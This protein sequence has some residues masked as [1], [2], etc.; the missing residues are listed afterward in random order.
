MTPK[1]EPKRLR[2]IFREEFIRKRMRGCSEKSKYKYEHVCDELFEYLGRPATVKD[3]D[4]DLIGD[5]LYWL[6]D[7]KKQSPH[8]ANTARKM[9]NSLWNFC[10]KQGHVKTWP[11]IPL[12]RC[13]KRA[14]IAWTKEQLATLFK[15]CEQ[16]KGESFYVPAPLWWHAIHCLIW[17]TGERIGAVLQLR[18]DDVDLDGCWLT[19]RAETRKWK[20]EDKSFR[21]HPDTVKALRAI[22]T[23]QPKIFATRFKDVSTLYNHYKKLLKAA[24]L[25]LTR[26]HKFHCLRK[27]AASYFEAAGGNATELLGHS[28]R[29]VTKC[30]LDP[31]VVTQIHASDV[32]FR[33]IEN[34]ATAGRSDSQKS[35]TPEA[36][37]SEVSEVLSQTLE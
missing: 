23:D 10:A 11:S 6:I 33:P 27:S 14:P 2:D 26:K 1:L 30:Y 34:T 13:P 32:L 20:R 19:I 15:A 12:V 37:T 17:D 35:E 9:V 7:E 4:D 16:A 28:S 8:S 3:L 36:L 31:R 18:W 21:L 25:P 24:G 29:D 22:Q 5:F